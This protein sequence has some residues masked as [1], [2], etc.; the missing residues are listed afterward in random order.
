MTCM[1]AIKDEIMQECPLFMKVSQRN[2]TDYRPMELTCMALCPGL[3]QHTN[4]EWLERQGMKG[5]QREVTAW[6]LINATRVSFIVTKT[7]PCW[8]TGSGRQSEAEV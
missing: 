3:P 6:T 2:V 8:F 5:G 1:S 7:Y 4:P